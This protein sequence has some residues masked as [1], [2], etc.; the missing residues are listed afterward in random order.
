L[1]LPYK[2]GFTLIELMIVVAI[3][4]IVSA[5]AVPTLLSSRTSAQVSATKAILRTVT[6]GEQTYFART[7]L[8]ADF[9]TLC[10]EG[11][12]DSRFASE[13]VL[14]NAYS[15]TIQLLDSGRSFLITATPTMPDAPI[16]TVDETYEIIES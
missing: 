3:I 7:G 14:E 15:I 10:A 12:L 4:G 1:N 8:F 2:S 9:S 16:L 5:I 11:I 13:P 6:A